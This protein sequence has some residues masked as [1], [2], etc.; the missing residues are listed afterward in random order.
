MLSIAFCKDA[1]CA[2]LL[3]LRSLF[4]IY[5]S[6][7][8][9]SFLYMSSVPETLSCVLLQA[10]KAEVGWGQEQ[11]QLLLQ[12]S[13]SIEDGSRPAED[14]GLEELRYHWMLYKS[15]LKN[16]GEIRARTSAKVRRTI[17]RH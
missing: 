6:M 3:Q 16:V 7:Y 4:C 17:N 13:Q 11:F 14:M 8:L 9:I 1:I 5:V 12:E 10:L 2:H 15:K